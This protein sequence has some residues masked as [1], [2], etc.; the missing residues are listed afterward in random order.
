M[1]MGFFVKHKKQNRV[2]GLRKSGRHERAQTVENVIRSMEMEHYPENE[3]SGSGSD[4]VT[5]GSGSEKTILV[6]GSGSGS[7]EELQK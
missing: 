5:S 1:P 3:T 4:E 7:G 2:V 6:S